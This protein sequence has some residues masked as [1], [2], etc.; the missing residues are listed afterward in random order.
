MATLHTPRR[1]PG[2]PR[3][4]DRRDTA[5]TILRVATALFARH[6]FDAVGVR[7]VAAAA[8]VDVSTVHHHT[9]GKADLY[10][11][12]FARV[13][14]AERRAMEPALARARERLDAGGEG[15][16]DALH[17]VLDAFVDFLTGQ[18]ET[19]GLWL[20]RWLEPERHRGLDERY[21]LPL[22]EAVERLLAD[23]DAA[24][25]LREPHPRTAVRSLVWSVHA[26]V[27]AVLGGQAGPSADGELRTFVHR[28]LDQ[29]YGT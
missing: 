17:D 21:S 4:D 1:R 24:G 16:L 12:C 20:R 18:P 6:G 15:L 19:T 28:W 27:V 22:Y 23:A 25:V 13:F 29:M 11:A 26:H 5:Q 8:G 10:E 2:R 14:E 7:H 3:R 9:G